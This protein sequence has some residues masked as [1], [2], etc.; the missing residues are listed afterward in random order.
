MGLINSP[1]LRPGDR[2]AWEKIEEGSRAWSATTRYSR[3]VEEAEMVVAQFCTRRRGGYASTSWGKDSVVLADI[4]CR[5][6]PRYPLVW[7]RV[8]PIYSPECRLVR[9][10]FLERYP[11]TEYCEILRRC[12]AHKDGSL[13]ATGTL[14]SGFAEA[15]F[16][17]GSRHISGI[18]AE[19]SAAR[20]LMGQVLGTGT[21]NAC[22][23]LMRWQALD[24]WAYLA[25]HDLPI[26]PAY[27][28]SFGGALSRDRIRVAS[29]GG[30]RGRGTGRME[31]E[32]AY[33][34]DI[35]AD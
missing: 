22:T 4:V 19:E 27:A 23:P 10:Q 28:M 16:R 5:I 20:K 11:D 31:W 9:D 15:S 18:R 32:R 21:D 7:V 24:V 34:P 3:H 13:S 6:M 8:E 1:R 29:I 33:Y 12:T 14:E 26:H 30:K 25:E 17:F 35:W 2:E